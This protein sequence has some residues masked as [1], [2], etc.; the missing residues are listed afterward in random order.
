M[1]IYLSQRWVIHF[2]I[3]Y[4]TQFQ[5]IARRNNVSIS[6]AS[7]YSDKNRGVKMS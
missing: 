3:Q 7:P 4:E 2:A 5:N 1:I 6:M